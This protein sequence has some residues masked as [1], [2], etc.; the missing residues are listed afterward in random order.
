MVIAEPPFAPAVKAIFASLSPGVT[1]NAEGALGVVRGTTETATE[2][3]PTPADV[4]ARSFIDVD[5]PFARP[6]I[7][8]G[9]VVLAGLRAV[10]EPVPI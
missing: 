10:Q 4:T 9:D 2:A 5:V 1:V 6:G 7:V 3:A 8:T